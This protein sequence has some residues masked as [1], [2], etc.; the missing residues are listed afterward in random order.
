MT[1][2]LVQTSAWDFASIGT[3]VQLP[4][5]A[6][7]EYYRWCGCFGHVAETCPVF[8][9]FLWM[10]VKTSYSLWL[11]PAVFCSSAHP[12]ISPSAA[13]GQRNPGSLPGYSEVWARR[14]SLVAWWGPATPCCP[15]RCQTDRCW[16]RREGRSHRRTGRM[17]PWASKA[18]APSA[19]PAARLSGPVCVGLTRVACWPACPP[20]RPPAGCLWPVKRGLEGCGL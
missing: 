18:A 4:P 8:P 13:A 9:S 7:W 3:S 2:N 15:G 6:E 1:S 11:S 19:G 20:G 17:C 16:A 5:L 14:W 10:D 12:S